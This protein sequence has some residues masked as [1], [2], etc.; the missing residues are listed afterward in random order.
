MTEC[1]Y[2]TTYILSFFFNLKYIGFALLSVQLFLRKYS[3]T[4]VWWDLKKKTLNT[5]KEDLEGRMLYLLFVY[6]LNV[7]YGINE[8]QYHLFPSDLFGRKLSILSST[9]IKESVCIAAPGHVAVDITPSHHITSLQKLCRE[10]FMFGLEVPFKHCL[11]SNL[12]TCLFYLI[13]S[14]MLTSIER[15]T[16]GNLANWLSTLSQINPQPDIAADLIVQFKIKWNK[17]RISFFS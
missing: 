13:F 9:L 12:I 7:C 8:Y 11:I 15:A 3:E 10:Y 14:I 1:Q 6:L 16:K 5:A 4:P 17:L 2:S